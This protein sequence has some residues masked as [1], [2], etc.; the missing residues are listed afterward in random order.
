MEFRQGRAGRFTT[1]EQVAIL[2]LLKAIAKRYGVPVAECTF[3]GAGEFRLH[4]NTTARHALLNS[5]KGM[6]NGNFKRVNTELLE[7]VACV[8]GWKLT[9]FATARKVGAGAPRLGWGN[10]HST[11]PA[12]AVKVTK[13]ARKRSTKKITA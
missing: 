11:R 10:F 3:N 12:T 2:P 4:N 9:R 6:T 13:K 8:H 7:F 1:E 5:F